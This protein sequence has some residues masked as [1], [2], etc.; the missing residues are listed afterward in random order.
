M[1]KYLWIAILSSIV[2]A[3]VIVAIA[4]IV[5]CCMA[6][7]KF[8]IEQKR[9]G[10]KDVLEWTFKTLNDFTIAILIAVVVL[11]MVASFVAFAVSIYGG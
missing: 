10:W 1:F 6:N 9:G 7:Y 8:Y 4:D 5:K 2:I 11:T 3:F